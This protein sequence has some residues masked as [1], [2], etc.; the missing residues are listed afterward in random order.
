[1]LVDSVNVSLGGEDGPRSS[2]QSAA[3]LMPQSHFRHL[4]VLVRGGQD[5][6]DVGRRLGDCNERR[7]YFDLAYAW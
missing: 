3:R 2:G 5:A 6:L 4:A 7:A 1:M